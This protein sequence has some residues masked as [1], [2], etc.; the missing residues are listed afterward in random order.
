MSKKSSL[1][2]INTNLDKSFIHY[3]ELTRTVIYVAKRTKELEISNIICDLSCILEGFC[4][5]TI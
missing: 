3:V 1:Q 2:K 4:D 5:E